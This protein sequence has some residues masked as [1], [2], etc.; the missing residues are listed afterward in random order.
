MHA[1]QVSAHDWTVFSSIQ[2]LYRALAGHWPVWAVRPGMHAPET[3]VGRRLRHGA[4]RQVAP[5]RSAR[6]IAE[7]HGF[8]RV[9]GIKN[10]WDEAGYMAYPLFKESGVEP[11]MIWEGRGRGIML[12]NKEGSA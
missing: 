11:P 12:S 9:E 2:N 4:L 10:T 3:S 5:G 1:D 7:R 8:R 6:A